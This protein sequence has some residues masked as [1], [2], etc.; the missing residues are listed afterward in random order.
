MRN[1]T[2]DIYATSWRNSNGTTVERLT[3]STDNI[4]TLSKTFH[5]NI[6]LLWMN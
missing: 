6:E 4:E 5:A 2:N 1:R 3:T